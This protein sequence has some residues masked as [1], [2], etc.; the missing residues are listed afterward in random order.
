MAFIRAYFPVSCEGQSVAARGAAR[1]ENGGGGNRTR[2][3]GRTG[4]ASTSLGCPL[5]SPG[6]PG[7]SRP[8]AGPA[9]LWSRA[10]DDWLFFGASPFVDAATRTTGPV[11]SD[12][13]PNCQLGGECEIVVRTC[14]VSRLF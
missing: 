14:F 11:R 6:R 10:S 5:L 8:T 7:C 2:V 12:A 1:R 13:S 9:I 3:R 4:R